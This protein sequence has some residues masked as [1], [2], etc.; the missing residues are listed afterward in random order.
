MSRV[1]HSEDLHFLYRV[2]GADGTL[3]YI[4]MT[5][6]PW[7]RIATQ[8]CS[9]RE[10]GDLADH[11]DWEPI[12]NRER[13]RAAE[14][15]AIWT[16]APIYNVQHNRLGAWRRLGIQR[17]A[18]FACSDPPHHVAHINGHPCPNAEAVAS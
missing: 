10:W 18:C 8:L 11:I 17:G 4:G 15:A 14:A 3:L 13:A 5:W 7:Q 6:D 9:N 2:Y 16:E 1:D 12:G